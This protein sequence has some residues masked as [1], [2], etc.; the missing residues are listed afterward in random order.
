MQSRT[1]V[2]AN[3]LVFYLSVSAFGTMYIIVVDP[4]TGEIDMR[5]FIDYFDALLFIDRLDR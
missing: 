4:Y 2:A 3:G 1:I 5:Y